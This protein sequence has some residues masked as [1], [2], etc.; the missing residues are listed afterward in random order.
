MYMTNLTSLDLSQNALEKIEKGCLTGLSNLQNLDL[1]DNQIW[2]LNPRAFDDVPNLKFL[3][4]N[5]NHFDSLDTAAFNRLVSLHTLDVS[6]N[7]IKEIQGSFYS[8]WK[9]LQKLDLSHNSLGRY[10]STQ[11]FDGLFNGVSALD[12]LLLSD[13]C[14]TSL[15]RSL[16][17]TLLF[18]KWLD[19]SD[20]A[21]VNLE[22]IDIPNSSFVNL[23]MNRLSSIPPAIFFQL[24]STSLM[25]FTGNPFACDCDLMSFSPLDCGQ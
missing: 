25:N 15:P 13:N 7:A 5:S 10:F 9:S 8:E 24:S 12:T 18:L 2:F 11:S 23:S 16:F 6:S 17:D 22:A 21:I 20:N 4:L 1:S 19:L 3:Y 14:I